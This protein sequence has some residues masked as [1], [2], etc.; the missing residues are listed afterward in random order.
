MKILFIAAFMTSTWESTADLLDAWI[1]LKV[2]AA[3]LY[4]DEPTAGKSVSLSDTSDS[5][6]ESALE[7][8][9][10]GWRDEWISA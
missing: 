3:F 8:F 9:L 2:R 5:L 10:E 6:K 1:A 7:V 4:A